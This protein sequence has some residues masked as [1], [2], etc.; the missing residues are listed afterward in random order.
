MNPPWRCDWI[1][2]N[3]VIEWLIIVY[4]EILFLYYEYIVLVYTNISYS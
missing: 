1:N 3:V 4:L 2:N